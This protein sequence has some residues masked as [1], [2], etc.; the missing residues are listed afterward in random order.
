[1]SDSVAGP[2]ANERLPTANELLD[3]ALHDDF[4]DDDFDAEVYDDEDEDDPDVSISDKTVTLSVAEGKL[5]IIL[6][7]NRGLSKRLYRRVQ[8][9]GSDT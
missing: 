7:D 2:S 6:L 9:G 5:L 1:V 8:G 3:A 4:S